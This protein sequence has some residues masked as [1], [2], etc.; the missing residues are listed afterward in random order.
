[1]FELV[2]LV[3][4]VLFFVGTHFISSTPLRG[5]LVRTLGE[6]LYLV[7]YSLISIGALVWMI[8]AYGNAPRNLLMWYSNAFTR[9]IPLFVIPVAFTFVIA[10]AAIGGKNPTSLTS[11]LIPKKRSAAQNVSG[12]LRITRHPMQ[13]GILLWALSH[14]CATGEVASF[15]FFGGFAFLSGV[16]SL[17]IDRKREKTMGDEWQAFEKITSNVPFAA[18]VAGKN[19]LIL[20]EIPFV[21]ILI[22]VFLYGIFIAYHVS[23][24]GTLAH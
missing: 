13:W 1:M 14:I 20:S 11:L 8:V 5:F 7:L 9:M 3:A 21:Q 10:G 16:G 4:S 24:F 22:A 17:S 18:I 23:F 19:R 6:R 12:I 2:L 15:L